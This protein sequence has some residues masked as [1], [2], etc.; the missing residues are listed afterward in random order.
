M[1]SYKQFAIVLD[2]SGSM[3]HP[4]AY[5]QNNCTFF[6]IHE[7]SVGAQY[8]LDDMATWLNNPVNAGSQFAVSVHRFASS[9]QLLSGQA[10]ASAGN[11]SALQSMG[12]TIGDAATGIEN[13]SASSAAVGSLTDIY[14]GVRQAAEYM[15]SNP[16]AFP[17]SATVTRII[18]L[19]TDGIQTIAHNGVYT[20]AGDESGQS[21]FSTLLG[22][23][24]LKLVSWGIGADA[25]G[26]V[27]DDLAS[28]ATAGSENKYIGFHTSTTPCSDTS[29]L[30]CALLMVND[31]GTIPLKPV[32]RAPSGLLWEQ[33]SL[34][35]R[36]PSEFKA[37][38][39]LNSSDFEV[40]VDEATDELILGPVWYAQ[41]QASLEATSPSGKRFA[42]GSAECYF[43]ARHNILSLHVPKPE[44]GTWPVRVTGD[45]KNA[46]LLIDL[47]ARG[48]QK[49]FK[50]HAQCEPFQSAAPGPIKVVA[51]PL[52]D[53]EP[54]KGH[55]TVD[56][57]LLG[58]PTV[59]LARQLDHSFAGT[60]PLPAAG[61]H[62]IVV[63]L[64]G[65]VDH[66]GAIRRM[67]FA[68]AQVGHATDPRFTL[69]PNTYQQGGSY[70]VDV[71]WARDGRFKD[72][73]VLSFGEGIAV[74][75]FARLDDLRA[76]AVIEVDASA[77]VG[78][79]EVLSYDPAGE[80]LGA[81][82]VIPRG[83]I[84]GEV[85]CLRF[86]AKGRLVAVILCDRTEVPVCVHDERLQ[87]V[88]EA[89]RDDGLRVTIHLD[90][91]GCLAFVDI[92]R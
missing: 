70:S 33:F 8:V 16:P 80:S 28:T 62:A 24:G 27:L 42:P 25:I 20:R 63:D 54:A 23:N 55:L 10:L 14:E 79:R 17:I 76:R 86:D 13:Q 73:T 37:T 38:K 47:M 21:A 52:L 35:H 67:V 69:Q 92:C 7:A 26:P 36:E 68:Q 4:T 71:T 34:P 11:V 29:M 66:L 2:N 49:R 12:N 44:A 41:G 9:Y 81:V 39:S 61:T 59:S 74:R 60:L 85:C 6:K 53:G 75:S 48:V 82:R 65:K 87:K 91:R 57:T 40:E 88:L 83:G 43:I 18:F 58:G 22:G 31:N 5:A 72:S 1:P 46:P 84:A 90:T 51:R 45:P 30:Q 77:F 19:F 15:M 32:G 56:A 64:K 89:A 78:D 50:L 3:Y